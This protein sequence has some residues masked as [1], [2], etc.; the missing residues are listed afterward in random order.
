MN[1]TL[2]IVLLD[3]GGNG[4]YNR[5]L[6]GSKWNAEQKSRKNGDV[7]NQGGR[8]IGAMEL[9]FPFEKSGQSMFA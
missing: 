8:K 7:H 6:W 3:L 9:G 2:R 1:E 5:L 4:E